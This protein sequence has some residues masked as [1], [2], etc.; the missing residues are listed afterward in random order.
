MVE[1][2]RQAGAKPGLLAM[3]SVRRA[4]ICHPDAAS[5]HETESGRTLE[6]KRER[7]RERERKREGGKETGTMLTC[8]RN[9]S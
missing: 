6:A 9:N 4:L 5:L 7:E 8:R 1:I 3:P 2:R